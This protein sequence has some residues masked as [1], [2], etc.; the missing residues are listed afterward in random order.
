[1]ED[2]AL[3]DRGIAGEEADGSGCAAGR[4][5]RSELEAGAPLRPFGRAHGQSDA[6]LGRGG[7]AVARV[8]VGEGGAEI[9]PA[10]VLDQGSDG[11]L[12]LDLPYFLSGSSMQED[13]CR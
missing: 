8:A 12:V 13:N 7:P 2:R 9:G 5:F 6:G 11:S 10:L 3:A 1:M 4:G